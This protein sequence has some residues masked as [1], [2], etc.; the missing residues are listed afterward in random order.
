MS[1]KKAEMFS[2]EGADIIVSLKASETELYAAGELER[3]MFQ[4]TGKLSTRTCKLPDE[5]VAIVLDPETASRLGI[6]SNC[7]KMNDQGYRLLAVKKGNLRCLVISAGSPAGVLYGV[8]G[9]LERLGMGFYAGGDTYPDLPAAAEIPETLDVAEQPEFKMRGNMLHYNFLCG[10]TNWGLD[11]YKFYFG[12]LARMRCNILLMHWYDGEP[13]AAYE[14]DGEYLAGGGTPNSLTKHWGAKA[15]LRTS[16]FSFGTGSYYDEEI[17]SSPMGEDMPDLMTEVKRSEKVFSE[18]VSYARVMAVNV[19]AGFEAPR[20]DPTV[21]LEQSRFK[22][23]IRQFLLRNPQITHFALWQH[24]SGGCVGSEAPLPGSTASALME[25]QRPVF[26]FLG[27]EQRVWEA[28]RFGAFAQIA[29][30]VLNEIAP[31]LPL[32]L[33]GWGGDL[34]M[35]FADYCLA[36]DKMF[37]AKVIFTCHDNIDASM[38]PNVSSPWGS[39]PPER[40]RWA[41]PWVE[42]DIEACDIRHP[43]VESLGSLAPDAL[44]KGCQGLLTLQ[45]RTRDVEEETGF[46]ARYAWDTTLTPGKFYR[47]FARHAFGPEQEERAARHIGTLQRLGSRWAGVRGPFECSTMRW[48]GVIPHYPFE[49]DSKTPGYLIPMVEKAIKSLAE[50]PTT[51]DSEAAFHLIQDKKNEA[52]AEYDYSRP[53]VKEMQ[54]ALASLQKM[55]SMKMAEER[56]REMLKGIEEKV[57]AVRPAL[58]AFGMLGKTYYSVDTFLMAIHHLWRNAGVRE[59]RSILC[60]IRND[61]QKMRGEY[62]K[63]KRLARLERLDYLLATIDYALDYNNA[64]MMLAD[65]ESVDKALLAA[66]AAKTVGDPASAAKSAAAAYAELVV[67][68]MQAAMEDFTRKLTTRCDFGTLCTLNVK[69]LPLYWDTVGRLEEFLPAVPPREIK[70]RGRKDEVW[71]SWTPGARNSGQNLYRRAL[72]GGSWSCVNI[73]PLMAGCQMFCD[74]PEKHGDYEYAVTAIAD[75]GWESPRSHSAKAV[76]GKGNKGPVIVASKPF[77]FLRVGEDL[78]LRVVA[79]SDRDIRSVTL[80]WRKAGEK[81]WNEAPMMQR[82]RSSYRTV[83]PSGNFSVGSFEFYVEASDGDA[84]VSAWPESGE[85]L[86]WSLTVL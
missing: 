71:I 24:E 51:K 17:F 72:G 63:A 19:A 4:L 68:G 61:L 65:N 78:S 83:V 27:N 55:D 59:H 48:T 66:T 20:G 64:A 35:Q 2:L 11:D 37:P 80:F 30:E 1:K 62:V 86:P 70:V 42:G 25:K 9:L 40:E 69:H 31:H 44:K 22:A 36:Y 32:V 21:P 33:V 23:R 6:K 52:P 3:Y 74:R 7:G 8:Y 75:G 54:D 29:L 28:I 77:T 79:L 45:W 85:K 39:L 49:V 76:Y 26:A 84:M 46:I 18:A 73:R 34:W 41:M 50:K 47:D 53:G 60:E 38:G 82:F 15:A 58:V 81:K 13:G 10:P 56:M 43:N 16:E 57:F 14:V 12:Q 67:S 5:G